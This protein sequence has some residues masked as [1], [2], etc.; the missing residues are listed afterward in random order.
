MSKHHTHVVIVLE[1]NR[2]VLAGSLFRTGGA[3]DLIWQLH[4]PAGH[5]DRYAH[6]FALEDDTNEEATH[7][8]LCTLA[9]L[10]CTEVV[11]RRAQLG[12]SRHPCTNHSLRLGYSTGA[13]GTYPLSRKIGKRLS[14]CHGLGHMG[15]TKGSVR[16]PE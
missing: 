14:V 11:V 9:T 6:P 7:I 2:V 10:A 8:A 12:K 16:A 1:G 3:D 5:P 13:N 4:L 15:S